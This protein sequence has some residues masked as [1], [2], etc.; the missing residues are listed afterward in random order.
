MD[1]RSH[2]SLG[3]ISEG[4]E[5]LELLSRSGRRKSGASSR[6]G[7]GGGGGGGNFLTVPAAGSLNSTHS[8][9]T[10]QHAPREL[11]MSHVSDHEFSKN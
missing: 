2:A 5:S 8:N 7:G 4:D 11:Y 6:H 1:T 10:T 9:N 3:S